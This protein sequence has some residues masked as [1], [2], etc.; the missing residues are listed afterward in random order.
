MPMKLHHAR[1][2]CR[3]PNCFSPS[4]L[5]YQYFIS[6][7]NAA[8][9]QRFSSSA[10]S[11]E[12]AEDG[13]SNRSSESPD[14]T[15]AT[16]A[17]QAI[18]SSPAQTKIRFHDNKEILRRKT[19]RELVDAAGTK[20]KPPNLVKKGARPLNAYNSE[21]N[22]EQLLLKA[23]LAV[24]DGEEYRGELVKPFASPVFIPEQMFP[25]SAKSSQS[26]LDA[27]SRYGITVSLKSFADGGAY[28]LNREINDFY[29]YAKPSRAELFA[30]KNVVEQIR[31]DVRQ[32]LPHH[33]LEVFGSERTGLALALSDI[34]LRLVN[35]RDLHQKSDKPPTPEQR[36]SL[37]KD[38]YNLRYRV[39][40]DRSR[41][42][43]MPVLRHSRY[44]LIS[45]LDRGSGLDVQ[46]VSSNSTTRQREFI[47][48]YMN[49]YPYLR[50]TYAV[51]KT[52]FDQRGFS[53][54]FRGGFGS[55]PLFMMIVASLQNEANQR[56]DAAGALVNFLYF[57]A[58]F[59]T[60]EHGV[61]IAPPEYFD[62]K[63][64]PILTD[65]LKSK[66][67]SRASKRKPDYI[68]TLRD[69]AD[70]TN[71]LGYKGSVILHLQYTLRHLTARMITNLN[72]NN[73]PS[74]LAPLVG[75]VY[76]RDRHRREHLAAH[77][78]RIQQQV[79]KSLAAAAAARN[80]HTEKHDATSTQQTAQEDPTA[81]LE[82]DVHGF[83]ADNTDSPTDPP[84]SQQQ[85]RI[86]I[87]SKVSIAYKQTNQRGM[88]FTAPNGTPAKDVTPAHS[89]ADV[90]AQVEDVH[91][92]RTH[93][94]Q[95]ETGRLPKVDT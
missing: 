78:S 20:A 43:I 71:D 39:F 11:P 62:K 59:K 65:T 89:P 70:E 80:T 51:I 28:R 82:T 5:L 26:N 64:N 15:V 31:A 29:E 1:P 24:D 84:H 47:Q 21:K 6:P 55:Y 34:D 74:L 83:L 79:E 35:R 86:P 95:Q 14:H 36:K 75:E 46:I 50:Q 12:A 44:P 90:Q 45:L 38:L 40:G 48:R 7:Y 85:D 68:L 19:P 60:H 69:P 93:G 57:W 10:P 88:F 41:K 94:A 92:T 37:L 63:E 23:K 56:R 49:E 77:G 54:V 2:I 76:G 52:M 32:R 53:D 81:Q 72:A 4:V 91:E 16:I 25:W 73:R 67:S 66:L 3:A 13:P 27:M 17:A 22:V 87:G 42:Y 30:R 33:I 61:S 9:Q 18:P 8:H 58:N